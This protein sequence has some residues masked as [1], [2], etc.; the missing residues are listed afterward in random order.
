M[1]FY[2]SRFHNRLQETDID[3]RYKDESTLYNLSDITA[4]VRALKKDLIILNTSVHQ[5]LN[6]ST[7]RQRYIRQWLCI[8][9]LCEQLCIKSLFNQYL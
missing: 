1:S 3:H 4:E 6:Q 7:E 8:S 5:K 9:S 2:D